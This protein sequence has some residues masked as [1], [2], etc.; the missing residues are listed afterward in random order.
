[1]AVIGLETHKEFGRE[2]GTF[3]RLVHPPFTINIWDS[4]SS[5]SEINT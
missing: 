5:T 4:D 1:M 2:Y 3:R